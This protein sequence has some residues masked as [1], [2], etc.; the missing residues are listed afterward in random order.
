MKHESAEY[1]LLLK[2]QKTFYDIKN[3]QIQNPNFTWYYSTK[4]KEENFQIIIWNNV[5]SHSRRHHRCF[6]VMLA[7]FYRGSKVRAWF[8]LLHSDFNSPFLM[9]KTRADS[10]SCNIG[11]IIE[12]NETHWE[13]LF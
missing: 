8:N 11:E 3:V 9:I 1:S 5:A 10:F 6:D 7:M 4:T 12:L 13:K 2:L